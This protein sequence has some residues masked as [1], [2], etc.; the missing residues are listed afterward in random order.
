VSVSSDYGP[1]RR[2]SVFRK[3]PRFW[4]SSLKADAWSPKPALRLALLALAVAASPAARA[5]GPRRIFEHTDLE[6]Q[7]PGAFELDLQLGLIRDRGGFRLIIPDFELNFGVHPRLELG[8]DGTIAFEGSTG[9]PY[10]LE[11]PALDTLWL[12]AKIGIYSERVRSTLWAVG[13]QL[14]PKLPTSASRG[15]GVESVALVEHTRSRLHLVLNGGGFVDP[16]PDPDCAYPKAIEGGIDLALDLNAT[17]STTLTGELA[18]IYYF[19]AD[20][21]QLTGTVGLKH[22]VDD[23]FDISLLVLVGQINGTLH[24]GLLVGLSPK[25]RLW[26]RR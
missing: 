26:R 22:A 15:V 25:F 1:R 3:K 10:V 13:L 21:Y 19:S 7:D 14:G 11:R 5:R 2:A 16:P 20:P 4:R 24:Y 12:S 23:R 18:G 6:M 8:L 9:G 17:A